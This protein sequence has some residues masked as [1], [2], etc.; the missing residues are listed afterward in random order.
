MGPLRE[1]CCTS[2]LCSYYAI[3]HTFNEWIQF[4][5]IALNH[6]IRSRMAVSYFCGPFCLCLAGSSSLVNTIRDS[7]RTRK[8]GV[9][10]VVIII[11]ERREGGLDC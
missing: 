3:L 8:E 11:R 5:M 10:E 7:F 4:I 9:Q 2:E 1:M 6:F